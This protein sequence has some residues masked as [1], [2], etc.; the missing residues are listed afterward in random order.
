MK[1][2]S[3]TNSVKRISLTMGRIFFLKYYSNFSRRTILPATRKTTPNNT[4]L[5]QKNI[6]VGKINQTKIRMVKTEDDWG[7]L[8][9]TINLKAPE[10]SWYLGRHAMLGRSV[11]WLAHVKAAK[12]ST[13]F[14]SSIKIYIRIRFSYHWYFQYLLRIVPRRP[15]NCPL[16]GVPWVHGFHQ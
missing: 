15:T 16:R 9:T 11:V 3:S 10:V 13:S 4:L 1:R 8:R 6:K 12:G 14:S 7:R 5:K 2:K